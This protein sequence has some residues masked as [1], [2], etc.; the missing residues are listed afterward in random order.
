[1]ARPRARR[2]P[3][4]VQELAALQAKGRSYAILNLALVTL[5]AFAMSTARYLVG[6]H[7]GR[8]VLVATVYDLT[9]D[10][11][12]ERLGGWGEPPFR[13]KQVHRQLWQ[14]AA[15]YNRMPDVPKRLRERLEAELP[16]GVEVLEEA[17]GGRGRDPEGVAAD[18][19]SRHVIETVL[20]GSQNLGRRWSRHRPGCRDEEAGVL[21]NGAD[22]APQQPHRRRDRGAG[23]AGPR[24]EAATPS[25][26]PPPAASRTPSSWGWAS[27]SR[28]NKPHFVQAR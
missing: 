8:L 15:T 24:R 18:R 11:L 22:G 1:M 10:Q 19:L 4:L 23:G 14:R 13:A 5:A 12:T 2:L 26:R 21:R 28:T 27:H 7:P 25:P 3:E 20:M 17:R 16:I 9:L 6:P